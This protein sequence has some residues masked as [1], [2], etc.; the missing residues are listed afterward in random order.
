MDRSGLQAKPHGFNRARAIA[1]VLALGI[2]VSDFVL[3]RRNGGAVG[4]FIID[5]CAAHFMWTGSPL[6]RWICALRCLVPGIVVL[7]FAALRLDVPLFLLASAMAAGGIWLL[8]APSAR[9]FFAFQQSKR[10]AISA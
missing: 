4:L 1:A 6:G 7:P 9:A 8:V 3:L 10:S 5:I 2:I